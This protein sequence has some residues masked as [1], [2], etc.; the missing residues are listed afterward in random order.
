MDLYL[1]SQKTCR[2]VYSYAPTDQK[3]LLNDNPEQYLG[4]ILSSKIK[5]LIQGFINKFK[6]NSNSDLLRYGYYLWLLDSVE[7][8]FHMDF[9]YDIKDIESI[10]QCCDRS[11]SKDH[12]LQILRH[13][14]SV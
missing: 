6:D 4:Q 9:K 2:I 11:H 3:I 12:S 13:L 10:Y 1:E 7:N 8:K 14:V 5:K